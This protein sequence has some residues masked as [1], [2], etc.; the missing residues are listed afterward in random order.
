MS[1]GPAKGRTS[2]STSGVDEPAGAHGARRPRRAKPLEDGLGEA[3]SAEGLTPPQGV[4]ADVL[5]ERERRQSAQRKAPGPTRSPTKAAIPKTPPP[6]SPPPTD[7]ADPVPTVTRNL[8]LD[9]AATGTQTGTVG[10][11]SVASST[12]TLFVTGNW[13]AS[14]SGDRGSTWTLLDPFTEFPTDRGTFCC[15]QQVVYVKSLRQRGSGSC[16]TRRSGASNIY[17]LAVSRTAA[18]GTWH[19]WD[20]TP[21]DLDPAWTDEW[22]DFPDLAVSAATS[23]SPSTCT[24][25]RT[26][27]AARRCDPLPPGPSSPGRRPS[28]GG[29]GPRPQ[30]GSLRLVSGADT[31]MWFAATDRAR[32]S[33]GCSNGP[34]TRP[35]SRPGRSRSA[36]GTTRTTPPSAPGVPRG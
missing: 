19:W 5:D 31:S 9:D 10:E 12:T 1:G 3:G 33:V 18:P 8:A 35:V 21:A 13:Y 11:P 24:T 17:R 29:T 16:S 28:P 32:R 4:D 25:P 36:R 20:V 30:V 2:E 6:D 14:R 22:F 26:T 34:T 7:P 15:D 23:G 27:L